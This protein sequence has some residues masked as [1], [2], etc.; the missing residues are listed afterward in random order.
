MRRLSVAEVMAGIAVVV[1][2]LGAV[3]AMQPSPS[4]TVPCSSM[5]KYRA[6]CYAAQTRCELQML[7]NVRAEAGGPA[8]LEEC[9]G[10]H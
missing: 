2:I 6:S 8:R 1:V 7:R 10:A 5:A 9:R 3:W 4:T